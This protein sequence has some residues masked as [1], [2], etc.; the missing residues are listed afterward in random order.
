MKNSINSAALLLMVCMCI[1]LTSCELAGDIFKA[2][3][4]IGIF[5]VIAIVVGI[6]ALIAKAGGK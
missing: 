2:G 4:G 3:M 5:I 6:V 1:S